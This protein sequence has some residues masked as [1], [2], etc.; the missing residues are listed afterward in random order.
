MR[1][2]K[3]ILKEFDKIIP[4]DYDIEGIIVALITVT[5]LLVFSYMVINGK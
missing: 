4:T 5:L 1:D 3:A 2:R